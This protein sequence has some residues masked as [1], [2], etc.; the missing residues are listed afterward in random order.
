MAQQYRSKLQSFFRL[1]LVLGLA[2]GATA[3]GRIP[4]VPVYNGNPNGFFDHYGSGRTAA[5]NRPH[6]VTVRWGDTL[7]EIALRN[8]VPTREL[9]Q[10]N[11][12]RAPFTIYQGQRLTVPGAP[13]HTV[14]RG[15]SLS[16]IAARY[17]VDTRE[18]ARSNNIRRPDRIY[19][20]QEIVLPW[21]ATGGAA[22]PPRTTYASN[23]STSTTTA[24]AA[25]RPRAER[26][27]PAPRRVTPVAASA[28]SARDLTPPARSGQGFMWPVNGRIISDFGPKAEGQ[29]NDGVNIA[30]PEGTPV[31]AAESGVVIYSG[32]EVPG[33]GNLVLIRHQ[34]GYVTAYAHNSRL[35]VAQGHVV[36][37]GEIIALSGRTGRVIEPQVHFEVRRNTEAVNPTQFL[38]GA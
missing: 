34:N 2:L 3:C 24:S 1:T 21:S 16:Q 30:V 15:E 5:A 13:T 20:G 28:V 36:E 10:A 4:F 32:N 29:H 26:A 18:L 27:A 17:N 14:R 12:I 33:Y 7:S 8:G 31:R 11:G 38:A 9:A 19:A 25:P 22:A 6:E 37:R 23:S 35:N